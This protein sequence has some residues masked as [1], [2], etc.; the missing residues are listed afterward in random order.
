MLR[1]SGVYASRSARLYQEGI[2]LLAEATACTDAEGVVPLLSGLMGNR[3]ADLRASA[4][5]PGQAPPATPIFVGAK[6][7]VRISRKRSAGEADLG[8]VPLVDIDRPPRAIS[9]PPAPTAVPVDPGTEERLNIIA[10]AAAYAQLVDPAPKP[11]AA[12]PA[13]PVGSGLLPGV[14]VKSEAPAKPKVK[15]GI[16]S[17]P[18]PPVQFSSK[19]EWMIDRRSGQR[20]HRNLYSCPVTGCTS[21]SSSLET[22][23]AHY[24]QYH[25]HQAL[26]CS[27]PE[28]PK[29]YF[30][31][32]S[33][34]RHANECQPETYMVVSTAVTPGS[35]I[36]AEVADEAA[37]AAANLDQ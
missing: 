22:A 27:K 6:P 14:E 5:A 11:E 8:P 2:R 3:A 34:V 19:K 29:K 16:S 18:A 21:R 12:I 10:Q 28:H 36:A 24:R 17:V 9:A 15:W 37:I 30:D 13:A 7:A 4:P 25:A 1:V 20:V 26:Q 23:R 35:Q 31:A 32:N 33:F